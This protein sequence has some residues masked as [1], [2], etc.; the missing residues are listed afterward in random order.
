M[1][2]AILALS[3]ACAVLAGVQTY[4]LQS[5]LTRADAA[6]ARVAGYQR[7]ATVRAET[8][9]KLRQIALD[10]SALDFTLSTEAGADESLSDYLSGAAGRVWP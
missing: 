1:T 8:D 5:A 7:A 6:E 9:A 4:R 3:L 10:A 2:R